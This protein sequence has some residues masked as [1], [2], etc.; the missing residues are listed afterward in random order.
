VA[1]P[2]EHHLRDYYRLARKRLTRLRARRARKPASRTE[3]SVAAY[4]MAY[5]EAYAD[6]LPAL[7]ATALPYSDVLDPAA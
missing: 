7:V 2:R 4:E 3:H 5:I 1:R 6:A